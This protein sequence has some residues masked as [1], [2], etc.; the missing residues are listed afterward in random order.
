VGIAERTMSAV[1]AK[2]RVRGA[3]AHR[4]RHTL[5][6]SILVNGGTIQDVADVLGISPA[7]AYRH[8]AKWTQD[9]QERITGVMLS[10]QAGVNVR[11]ERRK[12]VVQ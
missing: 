2:A 5:A 9:R 3:H 1:F 7:V 12:A 11:E 6:T 10:V 4:F 8:Y